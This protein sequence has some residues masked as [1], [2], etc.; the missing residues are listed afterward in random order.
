MAFIHEFEKMLEENKIAH[1]KPQREKP[2]VE[3][4]ERVETEKEAETKMVFRESLYFLTS[5]ETI[6][7]VIAVTPFVLGKIYRW[8]VS[9]KKKGEKGEILIRMKNGTTVEVSAES[10]NKFVFTEGKTRKSNKK[11]K[12]ASGA[13]NKKVRTLKSTQQQKTN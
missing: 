5:K 6:D 4:L 12:K 3:T 9:R 2:V 10:I 1:S 7:F 13:K 8:Y 11:R